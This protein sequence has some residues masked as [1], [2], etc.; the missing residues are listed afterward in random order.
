MKLAKCGIH[1][2]SFCNTKHD[3]PQCTNCIL[4]R[5]RDHLYKYANGYKL[6]RCP[7][8]EE[9]KMLNEFKPNSKG[10]RSWCNNCQKQYALARY[11]TNNKSFMIGYKE[12]N[13]KKFMRFDS[14]SKM[15]KF[16]KQHLIDNNNTYV[17]IKRI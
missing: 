12:D 13:K 2:L 11:Q 16:I 9:Y 8:C 17:E 7:H 10:H 5:H 1:G 14:S 4:V 3:A 15:I 6:K